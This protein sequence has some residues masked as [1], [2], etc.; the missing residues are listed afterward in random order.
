MITVIGIK[1]CDTCRKALSWLTA[2]NV[3]HQFHDLRVDG[4]T[5]ARLA[6]W[7]KACG[8]ESHLNQRS[9]T[10]RGLS[11]AEK[12]NLNAKTAEHLMMTYPTLIK[13]PVFEAG[14]QIYIGFTDAIKKALIP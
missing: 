13:R 6:G 1:S 14:G 9:T 11:E 12:S 8:W 5:A 2:K 3:A 7:V 4:L 10:W